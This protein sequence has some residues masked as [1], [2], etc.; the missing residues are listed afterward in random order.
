MTK[1]FFITMRHQARHALG[2]MPQAALQRLLHLYI[3][4]C[5]VY[6]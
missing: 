2:K 4:W 5:R 3:M 1:K 6:G